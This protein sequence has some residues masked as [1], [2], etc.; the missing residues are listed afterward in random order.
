MIIGGCDPLVRMVTLLTA[1]TGSAWG[2]GLFGSRFKKITVWSQE[3]VAEDVAG[4]QASQLAGRKRWV[5][6]SL[7]TFP[8]IQSSASAY[9]GLAFPL[10]SNLS[11]NAAQVSPEA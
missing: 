8:F 4:N 9:R 11:G 6:I 7:T 1:V 10:Q 3:G 2:E 5:L